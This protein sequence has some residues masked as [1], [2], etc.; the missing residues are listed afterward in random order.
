MMVQVVAADLQGIHPELLVDYRV[1]LAVVQIDM[2][3]IL[4]LLLVDLLEWDLLDLHQEDMK[5]VL[6]SLMHL[7]LEDDPVV[8]AAVEQVE[9]VEMVQELLNQE[10]RVELVVLD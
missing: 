4:E 5:V 9:M 10:T 3:L 6:E 8:V 7:L 1:D 2:I